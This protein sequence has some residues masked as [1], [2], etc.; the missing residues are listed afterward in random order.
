ML[1]TLGIIGIV[2]AITM[3]NLMSH[4]TK[5]KL[6]SQ[7]F[8]AYAELNRAA[9]AFY[10]Y[11]DIPFKDYQDSIYNNGILSSTVSLERFMSYYKGYTNTKLNPR[12]FDPDNNII[13][14]NLAGAAVTNWPCDQSTIFTDMV[15]RLYSLDDMAGIYGFD[16]GPK[17][18]IDTNGIDKP[19]R[20]GYDRFV[21]VFS[22]TNSVV[23]YTGIEWANLSSQ[24]TDDKKIAKYCSYQTTQVT[25]TCAHFALNDKNPEGAGSYWFDYL[26]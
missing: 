4:L 8:K 22:E 15:G 16:F 14:Q 2:A 1:I 21:F 20:W 26:K 25:H 18:C 5:Q 3:P 10:A 9:R 13:N 12:Q 17:I 19:N 24:L 6:K 7:F 23:P 11:E